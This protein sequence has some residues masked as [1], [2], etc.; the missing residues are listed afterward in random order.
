MGGLKPGA[1]S[2]LAKRGAAV[3]G[4]AAGKA[5]DPK[6]GRVGVRATAWH[7]WQAVQ[8]SQS[9]AACSVSSGDAAWSGQSACIAFLASASAI[10][11]WAWCDSDSTAKTD[12]SGVP[13]VNSMAMASPTHPRRGS[14]TIIKASTK[15][16]IC[17]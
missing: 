17:K 1:G 11:E 14:R 5:A 3:G 6:C 7:I 10:A 2:A 13:A 4:C 15:R 12:G 8:L 16:R 9:E